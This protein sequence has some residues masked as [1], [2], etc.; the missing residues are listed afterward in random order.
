MND[1]INFFQITDT[2]GTGGQP[3]VSQLYDIA[4]NGY[5]VVINLATHNSENAIENEGSIVASLGMT[6]IH[7]PVPFEAPTPEHLRKFFRFM[8]G[9]SE[10][11][12]FVHCAVNARVSAFVFKYLTMERKMQAEKATTPL[13]AQW[14]PQMNLIWKNFLSIEKSDLD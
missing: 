9:L 12:V 11:K 1:V 10:E 13:L 4:Q 3:S 14:L 7:I 2:I 6:Y 5:D 8:N